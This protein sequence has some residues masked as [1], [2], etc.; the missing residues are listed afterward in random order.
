MLASEVVSRF[1]QGSIVSAKARR[2]V[3]LLSSVRGQQKF[4]S[5]LDHEFEQVVKPTCVTRD[6]DYG[7]IWRAPCL[8]FQSPKKFGTPFDSVCV[9][10]DSL[11]I[12]DGWLILV[13]N[14]EIGIYR[15]E[16]RWDDEILIVAK[17]T[18]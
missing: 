7:A 16:G 1:V 15:P 2:Y 3:A 12:S 5:A 9:A 4:L 18:S 6:R 8:V 17:P 14:G 11:A 13:V 10:Y